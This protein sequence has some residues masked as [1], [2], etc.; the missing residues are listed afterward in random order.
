MG[1]GCGKVAGGGM[2]AGKGCVRVFN[3]GDD[4]GEKLLEATET[5]A[6]LDEP[7]QP[8]GGPVGPKKE[9]LIQMHPLLNIR[10]L[11]FIGLFLYSAFPFL[12]TQSSVTYSAIKK[13]SWAMD[14][15]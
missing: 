1:L 7:Q 10:L 14:R 2:S 15:M 13:L 6:G 11:K 12:K 4:R 8:E 5:A 9:R 3:T